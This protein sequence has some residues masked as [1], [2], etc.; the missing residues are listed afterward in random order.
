MIFNQ[1]VAFYVSA[2]WIEQGEEQEAS[3]DNDSMVCCF[4]VPRGVQLGGAGEGE[5]R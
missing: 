3:V 5:A 2:K 1:K 4:F